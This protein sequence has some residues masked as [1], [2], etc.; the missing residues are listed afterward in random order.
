[1]ILDNIDR[2]GLGV[3][4]EQG[5]DRASVVLDASARLDAVETLR[6]AD[7]RQALQVAAHVIGHPWD[8]SQ[9]GHSSERLELSLLDDHFRHRGVHLLR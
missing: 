6:R 7:D 8:A 4:S 3:S 1:M 5:L 9:L 2:S